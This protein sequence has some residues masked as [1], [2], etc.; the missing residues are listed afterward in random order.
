MIKFGYY[1]CA[2][3]QGQYEP[4]LNLGSVMHISSELHMEILYQF[5]SSLPKQ[6]TAPPVFLWYKSANQSNSNCDTSG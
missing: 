5:L 3:K 1:I 2:S 6:D 4:V